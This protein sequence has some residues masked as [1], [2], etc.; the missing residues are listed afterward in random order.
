MQH[1]THVIPSLN[2]Q[3]RRHQ[4]LNHHGLAVVRRDKQRVDNILKVLC[5][6]IV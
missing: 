5:S 1:H 4:L 6:K 2:I 3:A